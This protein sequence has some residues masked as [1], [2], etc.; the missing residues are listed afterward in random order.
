MCDKKAEIA[1]TEKNAC[2]QVAS[3]KLVV[4]R[5]LFYEQHP[6]SFHFIYTAGFCNAV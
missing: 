5:M 4:I 1:D 6:I 3:W 2:M